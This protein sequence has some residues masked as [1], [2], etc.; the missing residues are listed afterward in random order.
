MSLTN[1]ESSY[2]VSNTSAAPNYL[3]NCADQ[4]K[5]TEHES[6]SLSGLPDAKFE[7]KFDDETFDILNILPTV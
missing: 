2:Q 6:L 5:E 7:P 1:T 4:M 3:S